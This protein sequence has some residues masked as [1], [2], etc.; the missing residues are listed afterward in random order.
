VKS[1]LPQL[2]DRCEWCSSPFPRSQASSECRHNS[3]IQAIN[4]T[5]HSH[6]LSL[7][8]QWLKKT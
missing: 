2:R 1:T 8:S 7:P 4:Q 6:I 5:S 3:S